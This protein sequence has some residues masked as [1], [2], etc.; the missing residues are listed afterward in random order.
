MSTTAPDGRSWLEWSADHHNDQA[1]A[2]LGSIQY[3]SK[4][5]SYAEQRVE[6]QNQ[7]EQHR[8][9]ATACREAHGGRERLEDTLP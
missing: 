1:E 8:A 9:M 2:L 4:M 6:W 7:V 5:D 3:C